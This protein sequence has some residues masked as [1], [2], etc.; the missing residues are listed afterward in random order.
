MKK[1]GMRVLCLEFVVWKKRSV[2]FVY[3]NS[4]AGKGYS[5]VD[6]RVYVRLSEYPVFPS[7]GVFLLKPEENQPLPG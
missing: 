1:T 3:Q 7:D 5:G 2:S 4:G 6:Y